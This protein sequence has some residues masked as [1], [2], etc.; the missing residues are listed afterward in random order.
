MEQ[1]AVLTPT[2]NREAT[3]P[4]LYQSLLAQTDKVFTWLIVDDGST[5]GTKSLVEQWLTKE[6]LDIVYIQ[7]ENGGKA[8]ALNTGFDYLKD[9]ELA[10]VVDSDDYLLPNAI[11]DVREHI[12]RYA[13]NPNLGGFFFQYQLADGSPLPAKFQLNKPVL[14]NRFEYNRAYGKNDGC[15]C[16]HR[17]TL[18][19]LRYPEYQGETY[20]GPTVLQLD[21]AMAGLSILFSP[22]VIGIAEYLPGGLSRKGRVLRLSNPLG[23]IK[24]CEQGLSTLNAF[25]ERIKNAIMGQAYKTISG[26]NKAELRAMGFD[27]SNFPGWSALPGRM[28]AGYWRRR[29][30]L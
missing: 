19:R 3:L 7:R 18:S 25:H 9:A 4:R 16:Y 27:W 20:V 17:R 26:K 6:V 29:Y 2:Y 12:L 23:M 8:R 15:N 21:M 10:M 14:L 13:E 22:A 30:R 1:I 11:N 28:L 5:D 24:Y